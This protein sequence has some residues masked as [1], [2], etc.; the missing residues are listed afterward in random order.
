MGDKPVIRAL[1]R[2][3]TPQKR[4]HLRVLEVGKFLYP[5]TLPP[6][7]ATRADCPT[8]RPC[9][10][11]RCRHNTYLDVTEN[12][13]L[14]VPRHEPWDHPAAWSCVLDSRGATLEEVGEVLGVTRE[15]VRQIEVLALAKL[16]EKCLELGIQPP[17]PDP[18]LPDPFQRK[19]H[20]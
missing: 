7:P 10:H 2:K 5:E 12:G 13:S 6:L 1:K 15:R 16:H 8:I 19:V 17:T 14:S 3:T 20:Q 18:E 9:P 4:V 11:V